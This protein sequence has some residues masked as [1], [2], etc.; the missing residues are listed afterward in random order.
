MIFQDLMTAL[1]PVLRVDDQIAE[2]I[3]LHSSCSKSEALKGA[4]E[5]LEKV[6]IPASRGGTTPTSSPAG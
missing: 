4:L 3:R 6:G 2:V 1:N 5:M